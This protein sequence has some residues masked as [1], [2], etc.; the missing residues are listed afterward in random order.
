MSQIQVQR[1]IQSFSHIIPNLEEPEQ[2]ARVD[3]CFDMAEKID[4]PLQE[5]LVKNADDML[6]YFRLR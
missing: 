6:S 4:E 1:S 5:K 3:D 2:A